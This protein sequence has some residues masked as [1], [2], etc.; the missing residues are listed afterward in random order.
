MR[1]SRHLAA[2]LM[3]SAGIEFDASDVGLAS[4]LVE[5]LEAVLA[6]WL[7]AEMS[8]VVIVGDVVEQ[9][10]NGQWRPDVTKRGQAD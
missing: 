10:R 9:I 3:N 5:S 1:D 7:S 6:E 8:G 2:D 4:R